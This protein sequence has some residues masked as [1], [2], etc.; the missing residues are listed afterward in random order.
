M[1]INVII[2]CVILKDILSTNLVVAALLVSEIKVF[3]QTHKQ[4]LTCLMW[5]KILEISLNLLPKQFC[6]TGI[7]QRFDEHIRN[8]YL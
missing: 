2:I 8:I 7:I 5:K 6:C 4:I 3:I 1:G